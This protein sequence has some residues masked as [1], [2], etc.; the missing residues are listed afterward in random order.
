MPPSVKSVDGSSSSAT[1]N[2]TCLV[3]GLEETGETPRIEK[4]KPRPSYFQ[5]VIRYILTYIGILLP[6]FS[7]SAFV[8]QV[9]AIDPKSHWT[10]GAELHTI[11]FAPLTREGQ[12]LQGSESSEGPLGLTFYDQECRCGVEVA[13]FGTNCLREQRVELLNSTSICLYS[14]K[15][16]SHIHVH[17][18]QGSLVT[19]SGLLEWLQNVNVSG[20][21]AKLRVSYS[22]RD[23][24]LQPG[25]WQL[26]AKNKLPAQTSAHFSLEVR[27][28]KCTSHAYHMTMACRFCVCTAG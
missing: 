12:G 2:G 26:S 27:R 5:Y 20:K 13:G 28:T 18:G 7:F 19:D 8:A 3:D 21:F 16:K 6:I 14:F 1:Q 23:P 17:E 9:P 10:L 11:G 15:A 4:E 25:D 22:E 24:N